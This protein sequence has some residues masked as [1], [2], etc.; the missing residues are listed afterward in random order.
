MSLYLIVRGQAEWNLCPA[1]A[2][3]TDNKKVA[4]F[5]AGDTAMRNK[6]WVKDDKNDPSE[7]WL[8]TRWLGLDIDYRPVVRRIP[9]PDGTWA[10]FF[11]RTNAD[12][13]E[14]WLALRDAVWWSWHKPPQ[15]LL[16]YGV[17]LPNGEER[18]DIRDDFFDA[19]PYKPVPGFAW[20]DVVKRD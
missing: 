1:P 9:L 12:A 10:G 4:D 17:R 15:W 11:H 2:I 13:A 5:R 8:Y 18:L 16:E 3:V 6:V 19:Q 20:E 7:G 14:P